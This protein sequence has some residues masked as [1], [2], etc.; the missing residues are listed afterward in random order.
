MTED[1]SN[2][3]QVDDNRKMRNNLVSHLGRA[4]PALEEAIVS[5]LILLAPDQDVIMGKMD[6][7]DIIHQLRPNLAEDVNESSEDPTHY[8]ENATTSLS[9]STLEDGRNHSTIPKIRSTHLND[10]IGGSKQMLLIHNQ[11]ARIRQQQLYLTRTMD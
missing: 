4:A 7:D 9:K 1:M 11:I 6:A 8:A 10:L 2:A 5:I 3:Y